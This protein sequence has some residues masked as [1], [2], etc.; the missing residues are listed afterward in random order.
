MLRSH[1][2]CVLLLTLVTGGCSIQMPRESQDIP[3]DRP[4][5]S[6]AFADEFSGSISIDGL[7]IE[8]IEKLKYPEHKIRLISGQHRIMIKSNSGQVLFDQQVY[9]APN[10]HKT[11]RFE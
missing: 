1:I 5:F 9:L 3:D 4:T 8:S 10:S 11:I 6:V 2:L 7:T